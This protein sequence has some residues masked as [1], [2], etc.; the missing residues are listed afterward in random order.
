MKNRH[1][2]I[3]GIAVL[4]SSSV[5]AQNSTKAVLETTKQTTTAGTD[6]L[7]GIWKQYWILKLKP[8]EDTF[9][10]D[11][12]SILYEKYLG[13]LDYLNDPATPERYIPSNPDFYKMFIPVTYY[14]SPMERFSKLNWSFEG[15]RDT[16]PALINELLPF[17]TQSF[18]SKKRVNEIVDRTMLD[19]YINHPDFVVMTEDEIKKAKVFKDNIEKEV[20]SKPSVAKL[21]AKEEIVG[22][23]EEA[24]IVIHKPNWWVTGGS[25]SLQITQ[26]YIS[27]NWY[28][29][30]ESNTTLLA[31]LHLYANYNDREKIQWENS[32]DAKLGFGSTPSDKYHDYLIN[33]D[34]LRIYSKIGIQAASK[35]YYTISTE[36][37]TQF[38]HGYKANSEELVSAF[39]APADWS[40]SIGMD[41]KLN[42]KKFNLSVFMAP[43]THM[44]RYVGNKEVNEVKFGLDEGKSVM[45]N[46]GSQVQSTIKWTIIPSIVLNSRLDFQTS[47]EWTRVEWE[48]TVN[49][50]LNRYLSTKLYVH[51][52]FDDSAK[53]TEGD[54]YFQVKELL[55]F[56]INYKW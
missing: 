8:Y 2:F 48:N 35:W 34:Q 31:N 23:K 18:V 9:R 29:G 55:S 43:L 38:C 54:S 19:T 53:P 11:T 10:M 6:T 20:S 4:L 49:F 13:V 17:D 41:Y 16:L 30:G 52:R 22:V 3:W 15:E 45:H 1:L 37:K 39:F 21:F 24:G 40:S 32:L 28:K 12:V 47:Y 56:G 25:G 33:T 44:M 7:S 27:D 5:M 26:N 42:K 14:H 51:A 36:F 50:V 46:F